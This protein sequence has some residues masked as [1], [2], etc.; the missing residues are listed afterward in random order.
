MRIP[1]CRVK[2]IFGVCNCAPE[3]D[4]I[5]PGHQPLRMPQTPTNVYEAIFGALDGQHD[6]KAVAVIDLDKDSEPVS[7]AQLKRTVDVTRATMG[8]KS[9]ENVALVMPN[10]LEL[11]V[12]L[13]ATW[14]Q[15]AATAPL[16]PSYTS[17]EF[18]VGIANK[19]GGAYP[20][21][22]RSTGALR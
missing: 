8:V 19:N 3:Q 6:G 18:K 12:G 22:R 21:N 2:P 7:Y 15:G 20:A 13:L 9:G 14:A 16:N 4:A 10:S 11:I 17:V 1:S 5:F